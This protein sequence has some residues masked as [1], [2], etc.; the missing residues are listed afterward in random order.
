[1]LKAVAFANAFTAV[2]VGL[3][4]LCRALSIIA[5]DFLFSVGRSWFHTFSMDSLRV[6]APL[7]LGTFLAGGISLSILTWVA[8]FSGATLYNKLAR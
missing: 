3:Y 4:V 7:D 1:M 8:T 2:S 6:V 5:P